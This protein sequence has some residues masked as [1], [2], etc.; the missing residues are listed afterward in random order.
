MDPIF[1]VPGSAIINSKTREVMA[2]WRSGA[3][4]VHGDFLRIMKMPD[5]VC[6][7]IPNGADTPRLRV[8]IHTFRVWLAYGW[9]DRGIQVWMTDA[10]DPRVFH[11]NDMF[12]GLSYS[13]EAKLAD[14]IELVAA[15]PRAAS[16]VAE[17]V[18]SVSGKDMLKDYV[19]HLRREG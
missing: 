10:D 6:D 14:A 16:Y 11:R 13:D 12:A 19:R 15:N 18:F 5:L 4:A 7:V 17:S 8:A 2:H 3:P 1:P 9:R